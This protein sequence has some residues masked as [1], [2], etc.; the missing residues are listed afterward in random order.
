M[1]LLTDPFFPVRRQDGSHAWLT[2]PQLATRDNPPVAFASAR[3]DFD[4]ALLQLAVGL[5]QTLAPPA[6]HAAWCAWMRTPPSPDD[7]AARAA[8]YH[9]AF[10]FLAEGPAFMQDLMLKPGDGADNGIAALLIDAPGGNTLKENKDFF[11][12]RDTVRALCPACTPRKRPPSP[13]TFA[14]AGPSGPMRPTP[15]A[16]T[17]TITW[18]GCTP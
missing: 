6:D 18:V 5:L 7:L 4:G 10:A 17:A 13:V 14:V 1:N 16:T 15:P 2:W 3:P 9:H 11:Q 8:P 12:K